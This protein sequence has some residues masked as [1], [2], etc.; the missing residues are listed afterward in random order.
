VLRIEPAGRRVEALDQMR[1]DALD[2]AA[3]D[4]TG[5]LNISGL[6]LSN[7][8]RSRQ[9]MVELLLAKKHGAAT[10]PKWTDTATLALPA[11]LLEPGRP[12]LD[13]LLAICFDPSTGLQVR[14]RA[15]V[16]R[17]LP[18]RTPD[19]TER[20]P[21]SGEGAR[22]IEA[23]ARTATGI[24]LDHADLIVDQVLDGELAEL[25]GH[26]ALHDAAVDAVTTVLAPYAATVRYAANITAAT[27]FLRRR[28]P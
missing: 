16:R 3:A 10:S 19:G 6:W 14:L 24:W 27:R 5:P 20:P 25:D 28:T 8:P 7:Q 15:A 26:A 18:V 2:D 13:G 17:A 23:L 22:R 9:E 1:R 12:L 4:T 21:E 11:T